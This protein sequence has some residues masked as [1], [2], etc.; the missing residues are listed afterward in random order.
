MESAHT[1][2]LLTAASGVVIHLFL[3]RKGEW[4]VA[5][6]SIF[7]SYVTLFAATALFSHAYLDISLSS[8]TQLAA[9]HVVGLYSSMLVYRAFFHRLSEY[10]G[11]FLARLSTFYITARSVRKLHLYE[12]VQKLHAQYGDYVRLGPRELSIADP[13]AVKAIYGSQSPTTKGPWYTLLEPRVPLFMARDK[14]EH[15]RRRKVWDQGFTTKA[16][17]GYEPRINKAISQLLAVIEREKGQPLDLAQ[18]FAYLIF[19]IMED[20]SFNKNSHMVESGQDGY[21]FK[22]IRADMW[23]IAFFSHI[24]WLLPF[25][26][27]TPLL[28]AEYLAFYDWIQKQIDERRRQE[29]DRPDIFSPILRAYE[30]G[31]Q[32]ARDRRNLHGDAQLVVIAGSDSVVAA[33]VHLFF[34]LAWSPPGLVRRL[35]AEFDALP[36]LD[37]DN[38]QTVALLDAVINETLRLHPPVPS[39]TQRVTPPEGLAIGGGSSGAYIPGDTIVQVPSYTVFR[40]ERNFERA[41]EFVP[42]RWTTRPEMIKDRSVY[43]PFNTGPY[44]CVGKRL[45]ML[46]MRRVVA[47]IL[48]R[49]D[50]AIA[51]DQTREMFLDGKQDTFTT[52]SAPLP[53]IFTERVRSM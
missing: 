34:E 17:Q 51:P 27:R 20:L 53:V 14:Q 15:A 36:S 37:H 24:P 29:P 5:S 40:D 38:L 12:E 23:N 26:K 16:L 11:P 22:T 19:D 42:E 47:E 8:V 30:K 3:F 10:P 35:Q 2:A 1:M 41:A 46:E 21:I 50:M 48:S 13:E 25:L 31:P 39:G 44:G 52:V 9:C 45:A 7:V 28:N 6:P 43:I 4:D 33:L 18:W 32:T 49:Y